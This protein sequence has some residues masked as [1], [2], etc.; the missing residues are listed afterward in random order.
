MNSTIDWTKD[1]HVLMMDFDTKDLRRVEMS[2]E[3]AQAFWNL[4]PGF[5]YETKNGFHC[6][7]FFDLMPISRVRLILDYVDGVDPMFRYISRFYDRKTI[8]VAGKYQEKDINFLKIIKGFRHPQRFEYDLGYLKFKE[9]CMLRGD[10]VFLGEKD[11][12]D[13]KFVRK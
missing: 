12:I 2:I 6:I 11:L 10:T 1:Q 3:E 13:R 8:R 5:L 9:H 7:M 4:G